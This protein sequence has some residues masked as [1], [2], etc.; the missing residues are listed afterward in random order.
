M[1]A[2]VGVFSN[3]S[4]KTSKVFIRIGKY[5]RKEDLIVYAN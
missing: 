5:E 4:I 1:L 2:M 3:K